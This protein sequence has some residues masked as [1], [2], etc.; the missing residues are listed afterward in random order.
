FS[1]NSIMP[2]GAIFA[3]A[4]N[5]RENIGIALLDPEERERAR[6][7]RLMHQ[8]GWCLSELEATIGVNQDGH[9]T[10]YILAMNKEVR[11]LRPVRRTREL[12]LDDHVRRVELGG[13]R[14]DCRRR[15]CRVNSK[16]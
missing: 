12:L 8:I 1:Q 11:D 14:L 5:V 2:L 7:I 9:R 4:A 10:G 13:E 6:A 16:Q 3:A 15:G